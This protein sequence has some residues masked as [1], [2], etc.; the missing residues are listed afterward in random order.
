ML[1]FFKFIYLFSGFVGSGYLFIKLFNIQLSFKKIESYAVSFVAGTALI[2]WFSF[3]LLVF[4]FNLGFNHFLLVIGVLF[5][6]HSHYTLAKPLHFPYITLKFN[7]QSFQK[8][9]FFFIVFCLFLPD[10]FVSLAPIT[11]ADSLAYHL[12]F[13]KK[14]SDG[15]FEF[16]ERAATGAVPLLIQ[17]FYGFVYYIGSE[18]LLLKILL[19]T[20]V[21]FFILIFSLSNK[22]LN[23]SVSTIVAMLLVSMPAVTYGGM[24]GDIDVRMGLFILVSV[25][26]FLE[27]YQSRSTPYLCLAFC[28]AGFAAS[29]KY[30]GLFF[31]VALGI[32][33]L[34]LFN[35]KQ[36]FWASI[37]CF[38]CGFQWY[39][40]NYLHTSDPVFPMLSD[41]LTSSVW[42][43]SQLHAFK[44][45]F[46]IEQ[47]V[48]KNILWFF[49]YIVSVHL[50]PLTGFYA[51]KIGPTIAL[52]ILLPF[53]M[54]A[55]WGERFHLLD[56][57]NKATIV[58][59]IFLF[60]YALWFFIGSS[61]RFRYLL[62]VYPL[63]FIAVVYFAIHF[64]K[65]NSIF[66]TKLFLCPLLIVLLLQL[67][68]SYLA[69]ATAINYS[70][71]RSYSRKEYLSD[72]VPWVDAIFWANKNLPAGSK[73]VSDV[74]QFRS[75]S[76]HDIFIVQPL[77]QEV[78]RAGKHHTAEQFGIDVKREGITH[79]LVRPSF[80]LKF[81]NKGK[82][83]SRY[84][85]FLYNQ[86][87]SGCLN[88][89]KIVAVKEFGSKTLSFSKK[90]KS[91]TSIGIY[92]LNHDCAFTS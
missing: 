80:G 48:S 88:T 76:T 66:Y 46:D 2:G 7:K 85:E 52:I 43:P 65:K 30:Y 34:F 73:L 22:L 15:R 12:D 69:A 5:L 92:T 68:V 58:F 21:M 3:F 60:F 20:K 71:D 49:K 25:L 28:L 84:N 35:W 81:A 53:A 47:P 62:P 32:P 82:S 91:N 1:Q 31:I 64:F 87:Q 6:F 78:V 9:L 90:K 10:F 54:L 41:F 55:I 33:A 89:V 77:L 61:Q 79:F 29:S 40:W 57:H 75:L 24:N 19:A 74:R 14:V 70:F 56:I 26:F 72:N 83:L 45:L 42:S 59:S 4:N 16:I 18:S 86:F 44:D 51:T 38:V 37:C 27:S 23:R 67:G 8:I 50:N 36:L 17:T 63:F 13:A 11:N 39:F